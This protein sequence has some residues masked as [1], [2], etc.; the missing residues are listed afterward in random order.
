MPCLYFHCVLLSCPYHNWSHTLNVKALPSLCLRLPLLAGRMVS[1][2]LPSPSLPS[3]LSCGHPGTVVFIVSSLLSA[4]NPDA[5]LQ[6]L[7][8]RCCHLLTADLLHP[9]TLA[10]LVS[11][12][13]GLA[14]GRQHLIFVFWASKQCLLM[15]LISRVRVLLHEPR[16]NRSGAMSSF[17]SKP[18]G[19]S[20]CL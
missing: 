11:S 13:L 12:P 15:F 2:G 6:S 7:P 17:G 8:G 19:S 18:R 10:R 4:S 5:R 20:R 16:C 9:P 1:P 3:W 14:P